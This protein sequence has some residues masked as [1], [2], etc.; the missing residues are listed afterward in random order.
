[1]RERVTLHLASS[2]KPRYAHSSHQTRINGPAAAGG[3]ACCGSVPQVVLAPF[4]TACSG[5]LHRQVKELQAFVWQQGYE[6]GELRGHFFDD[7]PP[8]L[9]VLAEQ[10]VKVYMFSSGSSLAQALLFKHSSFGDLRPFISG[11]FDTRSGWVALRRGGGRRG[12]DPPT[13]TACDLATPSCCV[14]SNV[15]LITT[16][17]QDQAPDVHV[18]VEHA[19]RTGPP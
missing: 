14:R 12:R 11:F 13:R 6:R 9:R 16:Q 8:M 10:G 15:P 2:K 5:V 3:G 7:V 19:G 18:A 17:E 1:M 4:V